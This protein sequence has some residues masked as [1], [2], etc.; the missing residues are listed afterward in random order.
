MAGLLRRVLGENVA[1]KT[2]LA[3]SVVKV[4]A[5]RGQIEQ[6]IMN[7][8]VNARD[9]MPDGGKLTVETGVVTVPPGET[10]HDASL[11]A[12]RYVVLTVSDTGVGMSAA[13]K[14]RLFEPFFTTKAAGKGTGLGLATVY[15]IVSQ[16]SGHIRVQSEPGQGATFRIYLPVTGEAAVRRKV[17]TAP[18][19][20][21]GSE[22]ILLAEDEESFRDVIRATLEE[23]GYKV[24]SA[25][26]GAAAL[27]ALE[28]EGPRPD[29]IL[30]D[31][32]MPGMCGCDLVRQ[33]RAAHASV[34]AI[35]M[36]GHTEDALAGHGLDA[37][38]RDRTLLSKPFTP[39]GLLSA[40]RRE[41][42]E[43]VA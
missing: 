30:A 27:R 3:P 6:V 43:K 24:I 19:P 34:K 17:F 13:V 16:S 23:H 2:T 41:L 32:V 29:L 4:R 14:D 21:C 37:T 18:P 11:P 25:G 8:A 39:E 7:L 38:G 1:I 40:V 33:V 10:P 15:G 5:D 35:Y 22:T 31:V 9:A 28:G 26:N 36:S 42:D 20:P 12:G